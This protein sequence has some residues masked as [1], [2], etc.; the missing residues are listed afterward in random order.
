MKIKVEDKE[1]IVDIAETEE[2]KKEG[3]QGITELSDNEGMLFVYDDPQQ[4]SFWMKGVD[5]PLDIV[6]INDE[7]EVISVAQGQPNDETPI[8]EDNVMFVLE[9][10]ANS[11]IKAGDEVD[12]GLKADNPKMLVLDENGNV[13]ME[14]DG[15]ERI[16]SRKDTKVLIKFALKAN[17]SKEDKDYK[18]LG[19]KLFKFL[20]KQ[21]ENKP[22]YVELN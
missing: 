2:E 5:I 12:L 10:A 4:V 9:V 7:D 18:A 21:T 11:G 8:V 1:Y 6:F 14:L 22:Q 3:L 16:F 13:Q 19:S 17:L 15:G 20:D